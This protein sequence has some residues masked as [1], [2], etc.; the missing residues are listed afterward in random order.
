MR[1]TVLNF[2]KFRFPN[3]SNW[4]SGNCYHFSLI[5]SNVFDGEIYYEP[6]MNHFVTLICGEYYD[7]SGVFNETDKIVK[8]DFKSGDELS[9]GRIIRDCII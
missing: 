1:E 9:T 3:D 8:W 6:I 4:T 7:Y 5:L 2:I